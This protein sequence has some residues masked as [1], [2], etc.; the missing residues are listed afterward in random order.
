MTTT[1]QLLIEIEGEGGG[2]MTTT[3]QLLI[4]IGGRK[5]GGT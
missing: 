2:H 3:T 1:T 4:E 5:V